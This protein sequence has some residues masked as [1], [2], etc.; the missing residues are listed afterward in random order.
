MMSTPIIPQ[1]PSPANQGPKE[2]TLTH[3][4]GGGQNWT[5]KSPL[6][7][8]LLRAN[9]HSRCGLLWIGCSMPVPRQQFVDA[10]GGMFGDARQ[11]VGESGQGI[12]AVHFGGDDRAM[13]GRGGA[14]RRGHPDQLGV[15]P[16]CSHA[17]RWTATCLRS[18]PRYERPHPRQGL[19]RRPPKTPKRKGGNQTE[20]CLKYLARS[21]TCQAITVSA[22]IVP[23][24]SYFCRNRIIPPPDNP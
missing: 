22:H 10:V 23:S 17:S 3:N 24:A 19:R 13:E 7:G 15:A 11:H 2:G 18:R 8:S 20:N 1:T 4:H 21:G 12:G 14:G 16:W 6:K 9:L 5:R